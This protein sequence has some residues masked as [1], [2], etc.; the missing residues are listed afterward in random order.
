MVRH[1]LARG[2]VLPMLLVALVAGGCNSASAGGRRGED[3]K[4]L[5]DPAPPSTLGGLEV[6]PEDIAEQIAT[7]DDQY[8]EAIALYS[9]RDGQKA[10]ATL[11]IVQ[12]NDDARLDDEEFRDGF[13]TNL[14]GQR[15]VPI[16]VGDQPVQ[17]TQ[18]N[19]QRISVWFRGDL[20]FVLNTREDFERPRTLLREAV[21]IGEES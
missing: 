21:E 1:R 8:L 3:V 16:R 11:Q 20:A 13:V 2:L 9:I 15:G 19:L 14:G 6:V 7:V 5:E 4:A 18:G 10:V 12:F 17:V